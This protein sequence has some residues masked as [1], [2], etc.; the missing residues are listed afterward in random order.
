MDNF[1]Q[2][3]S[4][5]KYSPVFLEELIQNISTDELKIKRRKNSWSAHEHACHVCVGENMLF[6][7]DLYCFKIQTSHHSNQSPAIIFLMISI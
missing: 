1:D 3:I 2:I 5:L 7:K 4:G 6:I